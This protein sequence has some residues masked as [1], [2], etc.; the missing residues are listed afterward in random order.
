MSERLVVLV[1]PSGS[2]KSTIAL[3]LEKRIAIRRVITCT[4]RVPRTGEVDGKSYRFFS[5]IDFL[6]RVHQKEFFEH[7]KV[8]D[9]LYGTLKADIN[10]QLSSPE[11]ALL[12][13]DIQ[14]AELV[15]LRYPKAQI[16]FITAPFEQLVRRLNMRNMTAEERER[17]KQVLFQELGGERSICVKDVIDNPDGKFDVA[18]QQ[19]V[20]I[21][22][23][24]LNDQ[25]FG[26]PRC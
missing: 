11:L 26:K 10:Q 4:T 16:F 6:R 5:W 23:E 25:H 15:Y 22:N 2:G 17:R 12:V 24:K 13:M 14:G 18:V 1:G 20:D 8:H 7:A 21:I 9:C 19:I 3:E